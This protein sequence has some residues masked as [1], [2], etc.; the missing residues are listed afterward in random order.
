MTSH[1]ALSGS[2]RLRRARKCPNCTAAGRLGSDLRER[3]GTFLWGGV[4]VVNQR[5]LLWPWVPSKSTGHWRQ[6]AGRGGSTYLDHRGPFEEPVSPFPSP[7][8]LR[9]CRPWPRNGAVWPGAPQVPLNYKVLLRQ[10]LDALSPATSRRGVITTISGKRQGCF[11]K[12]GRGR[13]MCGILM[14]H[15]CL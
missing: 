13:I 15:N 2:S 5:S 12:M 11:S 10:A 8:P 1:A 9:G 14:P 7:R 3:Q 6:R 4:Q